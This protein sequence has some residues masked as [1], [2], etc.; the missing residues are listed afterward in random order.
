MTSFGI[1]GIFLVLI[2]N[3]GMASAAVAF[4]PVLSPYLHCTTNARAE[5]RLRQAQNCPV[6]LSETQTPHT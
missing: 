4:G 3:T 2:C 6:S 5:L 1:P